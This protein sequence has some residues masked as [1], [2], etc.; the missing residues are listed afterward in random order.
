MIKIA[1]V[2]TKQFHE[3]FHSNDTSDIITGSFSRENARYE[4]GAF[5]ADIVICDEDMVEEVT[6]L[7]NPEKHVSIFLAVPED[8]EDLPAAFLEGRA[9]E[10]LTFPP[11]RPEV[12]SKIKWHYHIRSLK[13]IEGETHNLHLL[14]EKLK[15]DVQLA[16]KVQRKLIKDKFPTMGGI[17]VKS[18]Y[19]C[20]LKGGGDYFDVYEMKAS[21]QMA[22]IL[23]NATSFT[24]S[25]AFLSSLLGLQ[26][27]EEEQQHPHLALHKIYSGLGDS[28]TDKNEL[29]IFL[30]FIDQRTYEMQYVAHGRVWAALSRDVDVEWLNRAEN[31]ALSSLEKPAARSEAVLLEPNNRLSLFSDG[32]SQVLTKEQFMHEF[33]ENARERDA[34]RAINNF[35][36]MLKKAS[37]HEQSGAV[38]QMPDQDCSVLLFDVAKNVLRLA[39]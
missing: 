29:S 4:L 9:D 28:L 8:S 16:E 3:Y 1:L 38:R 13:E 7:L 34:Q 31:N 37:K 30:A 17:S 24:L 5:N 33:A 14:V 10:I 23:S 18:K 25:S 39:T 15:D 35:G 19:W 2:D 6:S 32:F 11:R 20:G 27:N 26:L 22:I 21:N 36:F 12:L